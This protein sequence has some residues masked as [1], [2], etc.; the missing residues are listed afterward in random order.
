MKK[1]HVLKDIVAIVFFWLL[2]IGILYI[3]WLK[4]KTL[5]F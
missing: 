2:A 1:L 4:I 3:A 5:S